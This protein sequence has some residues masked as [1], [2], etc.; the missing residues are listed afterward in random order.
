MFKYDN[1]P[2][3]TAGIVMKYLTD[4]KIKVLKYIT[5]SPDLN[6]PKIY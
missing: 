6:S 4:S 1:D 2:K 3:H 5:Q